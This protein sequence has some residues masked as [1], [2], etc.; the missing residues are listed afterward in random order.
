MMPPRPLAKGESMLTLTWHYDLG[1]I[2]MPEILPHIN[3]WGGLGNDVNMG[4]AFQA[5]FC[6]SYLAAAKYYE[7]GQESYAT[8][9]AQLGQLIGPNNNP[10]LEA[11][12]AYFAR[13]GD[14]YL[15]LSSGVAYG[16]GASYSPV[17]LKSR[18]PRQLAA[19]SR[20]LPLLSIAGGTEQGTV[21]LLYYH[22]LTEAALDT[23]EKIAQVADTVVLTVDIQAGDDVKLIEE[24]IPGFLDTSFVIV[25]PEGDTLE[26]RK[27]FIDMFGDA[28]PED[29]IRYL[30]PSEYTVFYIGKPVDMKVM[31]H[32]DSLR[33]LLDSSRQIEIRRYGG[34]L[35][36]SI[37]SARERAKSLFRDLSFGVGITRT[38][39]SSGTIDPR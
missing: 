19:C 31:I 30:V 29:Q 4:T 1:R 9:Y 13:H 33:H 34:A 32:G 7:S 6:F 23:Y 24:G 3:V 22:G 11:G 17:F 36:E 15:K 38:N 14:A 26:L 21:S 12:G 18:H 25:T 2:T 5:P 37:S 27:P 8:L 16:N 10:Y 20:V 39:S 28:D 35:E